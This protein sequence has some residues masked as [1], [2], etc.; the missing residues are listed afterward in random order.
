[1]GT[2]L[3]RLRYW[4][5]QLQ[6]PNYGVG[7]IAAK[8][9]SLV[10]PTYCRGEGRTVRFLLR[11]AGTPPSLGRRRVG[12]GRKSH[13]PTRFVSV[14]RPGGGGGCKNRHTIF[15]SAGPSRMRSAARGAGTVRGVASVF[16][17]RRAMT[18]P[19]NGCRPARVRTR[20]SG[21][22]AGTPRRDVAEDVA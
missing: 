2:P 1:M 12:T 7:F 15:R 11:A 14:P 13:L 8:V 9:Q 16:R 6:A 21:R 19:E 10:R 22:A 5:D 17:R 4:L 3:G 20:Y 18:A